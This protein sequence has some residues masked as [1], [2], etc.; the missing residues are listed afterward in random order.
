MRFQGAQG[1]RPAKVPRPLW[2]PQA[3]TVTPEA[4][5]GQAHEL[6]PFLTA[7]GLSLTDIYPRPKPQPPRPP[8]GHSDNS[9]GERPAR[10]G[11]V[12]PLSPAASHFRGARPSHPSPTGAS[13]ASVYWRRPVTLPG[14]R[15]LIWGTE[16][17]PLN[18]FSRT[19]PLTSVLR[20]KV[21]SSTPKLPPRSTPRPGVRGLPR[22][23]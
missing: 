12:R 16:G 2:K 19:H 11:R 3:G 18:L 20:C 14:T 1:R 23:R 22:R 15:G 17:S 13:G 9:G 4:R 6:V 21:P 7:S 10:L 8:P 5:W